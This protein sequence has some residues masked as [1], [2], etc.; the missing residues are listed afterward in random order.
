MTARGRRRR[1]QRLLAALAPLPAASAHE[2][3]CAL[4]ADRRGA[5]IARGTLHSLLVGCLAEGLIGVEQGGGRRRYWLTA[6]GRRVLNDLDAGRLR[7]P[8]VR[9]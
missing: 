8:E 1:T 9:V 5:R 3:A 6:L 2:V 7:H 4:G